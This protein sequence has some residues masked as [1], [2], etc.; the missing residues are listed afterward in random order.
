[1]TETRVRQR[2]EGTESRVRQR[3]EGERDKS[4]T[5]KSEAETRGRQ[6]RE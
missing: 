6:R 5:N 1:M 2:Q 3:Q 4:E